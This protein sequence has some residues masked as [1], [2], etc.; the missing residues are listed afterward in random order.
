MV[1]QA[2]IVRT[3]S[4]MASSGNPSNGPT[5]RDKRIPVSLSCGTVAVKE[6]LLSV[7]VKVTI[8]LLLP[9]N[10]KSPFQRRVGCSVK[11]GVEDGINMETGSKIFNRI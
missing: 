1:Q 11:L 3:R 2:A 4:R 9:A 7:K 5:L 10:W 8:T 6:N